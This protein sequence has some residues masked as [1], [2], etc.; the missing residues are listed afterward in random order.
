MQVLKPNGIIVIGLY[1]KYGRTF[2]RIKQKLANI[3]GSRIYFFDKTSRD[4]K[5]KDKRKAWVRDQFMNPHETLHTPNEVIKWFE[6]NNIEF[7]NLIPYY[8]NTK[9]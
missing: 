2:T 9:K 6:E 4:I 5:S 3:I 7:Q 8:Y 1:H